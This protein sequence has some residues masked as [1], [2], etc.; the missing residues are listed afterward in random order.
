MLEN[1]Y[2]VSVPDSGNYLI[3]NNNS[4]SRLKSTLSG[5]SLFAVMVICLTA[6][7]TPNQVLRKT[8]AVPPRFVRK[9]K[10]ITTKKSCQLFLGQINTKQGSTDI[11]TC[12]FIC[13]EIS[14]LKTDHLW[15]KKT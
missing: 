13:C 7:F 15:K 2:G 12:V 5:L 3:L 6:A 9:I 1:I 8:F 10:I 4:A 14:K 11:Q